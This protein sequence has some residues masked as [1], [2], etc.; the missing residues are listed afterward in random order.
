MSESPIKVAM[1]CCFCTAGAAPA[2]QSSAQWWLP[3]VAPSPC[4]QQHQQQASKTS[5]SGRQGQQQQ[6]VATA[7]PQALQEQELLHQAVLPTEQLRLGCL[8]RQCLVLWW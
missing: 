2:L 3:A 5:Q 6:Q 8:T 4:H 7:D 1:C